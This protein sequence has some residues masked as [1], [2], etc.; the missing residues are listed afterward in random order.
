MILV[1]I[2]VGLIWLGFIGLNKMNKNYS[3]C[4]DYPPCKPNP[5]PK[6]IDYD[7][8]VVPKIIAAMKRDGELV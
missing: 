6:P 1:I 5:Q 8:R 2:T 3:K 7:L 4:Q